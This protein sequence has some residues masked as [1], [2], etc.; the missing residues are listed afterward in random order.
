ML[1]EGF[2]PVIPPYMTR[3]EIA[4]GMTDLAWFDETMY[5]VDGEDLFPDSPGASIAV[6][7]AVPTAIAW[8][9]V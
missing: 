5:K 7:P 3:H 8:R 6:N 2:T 1:A 9:E 4:A